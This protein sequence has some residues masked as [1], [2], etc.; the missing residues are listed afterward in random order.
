M[1]GVVIPN[2]SHRL[3]VIAADTGVGKTQIATMVSMGLVMNGCDVL[4]IS[5]A[6]C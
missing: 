6:H 1:I 4:F 2:R 3:H 5:G